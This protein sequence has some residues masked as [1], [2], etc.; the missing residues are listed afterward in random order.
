M[1][2]F[3]RL[4]AACIALAV[5]NTAGAQ[6]THYPNKPVRLLVPFAPGGGTDIIA[7]SMAQK[8]TEAFK[9]AVIV[10]NRAG[11]GGTVVAL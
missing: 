4:G 11:G 1:K 7:R 5:L 3:I 10:D 9:Q 8:L 6:S 2:L